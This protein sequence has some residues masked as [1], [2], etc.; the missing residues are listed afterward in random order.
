MYDHAS[1]EVA[2]IPTR[3]QALAVVTGFVAEQMGLQV[4][5]VGEA[6]MLIADIHCDSLDVVEITMKIEQHYEITMSDEYFERDRSV[7]GITDY[8]LQL[9]A[10]IPVSQG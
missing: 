3:N 1:T 2:K 8:L 9:L 6:D 7:G 5:Q 4:Q 10:G